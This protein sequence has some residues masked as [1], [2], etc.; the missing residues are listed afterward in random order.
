MTSDFAILIIF[1]DYKICKLST[2]RFNVEFITNTM[3]QNP[4]EANSHTA[5][6]E[7][8]HL[9]WNPNV[10][11]CVQKGPSP[12][13]VLYEKNSVYTSYPSSLRSVLT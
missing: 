1:H 10:Y 2:S 11:Y 3:E 5:S 12:V 8:P 6:Q 13:A 4:P 9:L 7:I